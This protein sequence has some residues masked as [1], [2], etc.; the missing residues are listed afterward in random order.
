MIYDYVVI[1]SGIIGTMIARELSRYDVSLLVLEKENDIANHQTTA[2]S[3]IIHSGH[4]PKEG[5]L[6]AKLCVLGNSL[7]NKLEKELDIPLLRTG[8]FVVAHDQDEEKML[9]QLYQRGLINGVGEMMLLSGDEARRQE[10]LLSPSITKVLSLP[11]TK[12]TYPWEVAIAALG[13][14]IKNGATFQ[15]NSEVVSMNYNDGV[16]KIGLKNGLNVQTK[17]II[18]AAGL[19]SDHVALMLEKE[20][21]LTIKPRKGEY[22]VLDR[23]A[24]DLFHKVIYPLPTSSGKGVL[25]VPQVHG[26]ILL[27]PTSSPVSDPNKAGTTKDGMTYIK[28]HLKKLSAHIPYDMVIRTFAGIRASSTYDDFYIKESSFF[29]GFYHVAGIDSPG[30]TAAPAIATYLI[31]E[32]IKLK[33]NQKENFDPYRVKPIPFHHRSDLDKKKMIEENPKYGHLVCKCEKITEQEII[34]AITGPTGNETIKGIKKRARAGSGLCQGGYCESRVLKIISK[35]TGKSLDEIN[36]Y[37]EHT[38]ILMKETK[39]HD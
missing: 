4:D 36:Y 34:D 7:Y 9:D 12:V 1:G 29:P 11:T 24:K 2:N 3:A 21:E 16:Y 39:K 13:N 6:K 14:A 38:P 20:F 15:R 26:N 37:A 32:I 17:N 22:L 18:N 27:G 30:L 5:T 19:W 28:D 25:I 35:T 10:P 23:K 33:A 8:A 31:N